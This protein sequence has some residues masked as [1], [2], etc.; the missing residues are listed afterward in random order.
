[1]I[2]IGKPRK[3]GGDGSEPHW[4]AVSLFE[5]LSYIGGRKLAPRERCLDQ[6]VELP[7]KSV[8]TRRGSMAIFDWD[9]YHL[10]EGEDFHYLFSRQISFEGQSVHRFFVVLA[11]Q[12]G[13]LSQL[14]QQLP[15]PGL[16]K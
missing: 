16:F 5:F 10:H 14:S 8:L 7:E 12:L 1:M 13:P 9:V 11:V 4:R 15:V 6:T 3:I 2:L